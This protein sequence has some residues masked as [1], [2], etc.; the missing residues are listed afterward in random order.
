LLIDAL[1]QKA[2]S[3]AGKGRRDKPRGTRPD[4]HR[5]HASD[6][7]GY[8]CSAWALFEA[9]AG[10][11]QR[12]APM[13]REETKM[14]QSSRYLVIAAA[15]LAGGSLSAMAQ[16]TGLGGGLS[17]PGATIGGVGA[18]GFGTNTG[19]GA[20]P[21]GQGIGSTTGTSIGSAGLSPAYGGWTPGT[22]SIGVGGVGIGV[23]TGTL[24][25]VGPYYGSYGELGGYG[26]A[27]LGGSTG[28][29]GNTTANAANGFSRF[30]STTV[31]VG[32]TT[33]GFGGTATPLGGTTTGAGGTIP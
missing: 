16:T 29:L 18:T 3:V 1:Q 25:G 8:F 10:A 33:S 6:G 32:S 11:L 4:T 26:S 28:M 9:A 30:P 23:G 13:R 19:I 21:G 7:V 2:A 22:S 5:T 15:F 17:I 14:R 12:H 24:G 27:A 31:G 20:L